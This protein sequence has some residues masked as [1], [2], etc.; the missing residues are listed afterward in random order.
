M[1]RATSDGYEA[2]TFIVRLWRTE[3]AAWRGSAVHVQSGTERHI[4]E[5]DTLIDFLQTWMQPLDGEGKK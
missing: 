3:N 4:Q 1:K 2:A 5:M